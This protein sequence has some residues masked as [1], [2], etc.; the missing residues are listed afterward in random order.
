MLGPRDVVFGTAILGANFAANGGGGIHAYSAS[1]TFDID[2][3]GD[4][5]LGLID[6]QTNGFNDELGF[7]SIEFTVVVGGV[8]VF[9]PPPFTLL[10]NAESFFRDA[11]FDLGP[12]LGQAATFGYTLVA[13]GTGGFGFDFAVG[14]TVPEAP[15]WMMML[16]GFAGLGYAACRSAKRRRRS[17]RR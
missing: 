10:S 12:S 1:T 7:Q 14:G 16:T 5:L 2:Y 3:H 15:T 17:A 4:L 11:V 9:A 13:N 8:T 6:N